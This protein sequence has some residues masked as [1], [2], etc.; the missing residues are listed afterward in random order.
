M[1]AR[2]GRLRHGSLASQLAR[3]GLPAAGSGQLDCAGAGSVCAAQVWSGCG[4]C[5]AA[6]QLACAASVSFLER[7]FD[8]VRVIGQALALVSEA[9]G[10]GTVAGQLGVTL[11]AAP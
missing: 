5:E 2:T 3:R 10:D 9:S 4:F 1:R 8:E 11:T 7:R 6:G